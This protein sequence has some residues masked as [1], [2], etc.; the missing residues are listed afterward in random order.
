MVLGFSPEK[1]QEEKIEDN[2]PEKSMIN[3][4][5]GLSFA[6]RTDQTTYFRAMY[7]FIRL[8]ETTPKMNTQ[9]HKYCIYLYSAI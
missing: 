1:L 5:K 8:D 2:V 3:P 4:V 9:N 6:K 7:H